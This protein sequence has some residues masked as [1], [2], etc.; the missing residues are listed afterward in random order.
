[1]AQMAPLLALISPPYNGL[2]RQPQLV[3]QERGMPT[4]MISSPFIVVVGLKNLIRMRESAGRET[5]PKRGLELFIPKSG[6]F[7]NPR[8]RAGLKNYLAA[9][10]GS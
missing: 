6:V 9:S 5:R 2:T 7:V 4:L 1:M 8:D 10:G 3:G